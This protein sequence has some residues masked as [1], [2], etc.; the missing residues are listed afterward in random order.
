MGAS[1]GTSM[2]APHVAG[3]A[4]LYLQSNPGA[5][6]AAVGE[7]IIGNAT[8][9]LLKGVGT[10]SVNLLLR[11]NGAASLPAVP[12]ADTPPVA[13]FTSKCQKGK[14]TFNAAGSTD[15][16]GIVNYRWMFGDGSAELAPSST[17]THMYAAS[18]TMTVTLTVTDAASRSAPTTSMVTVRAGR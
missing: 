17:N 1:W 10:T 15:D 6:P 8:P 13:S 18:G 4:S 3:A 9:G 7:A 12:P 11:V 2:A 14:C 5:L 16:K